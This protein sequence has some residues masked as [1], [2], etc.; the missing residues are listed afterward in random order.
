MSERLIVKGAR[1]R[2]MSSVRVDGALVASAT[3]AH[4]LGHA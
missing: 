3:R 4:E 2:L 1:Q